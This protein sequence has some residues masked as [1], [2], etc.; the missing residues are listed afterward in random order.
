MKD[1][2]EFYTVVVIG[3][4]YGGDIAASRLAPW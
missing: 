3:S 4:G 2:K 1:L